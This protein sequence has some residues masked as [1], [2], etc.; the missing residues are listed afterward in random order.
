MIAIAL[1][2]FSLA[3]GFAAGWLFLKRR[4]ALVASVLWLTT[5]FYNAWILAGCSG[6]CNIRV[7]LLLVLPLLLA[8]SIAA[9]ISIV[10]EAWRKKKALR[11]NTNPP[12]EAS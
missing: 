9:L 5:P 6:D 3:I 11:R 12:G 4:S 2:C 8:A 10:R 1:I 7:D